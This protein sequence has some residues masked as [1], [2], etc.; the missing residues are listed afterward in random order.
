MTLHMSLWDELCSTAEEHQASI[1]HLQ[2]R[3]SELQAEVQERE[4]RVLQL[5]ALVQ[6]GAVSSA[7]GQRSL[8]DICTCVGLVKTDL[9]Q[10]RKEQLQS[11]AQVSQLHPCPSR[12]GDRLYICHTVC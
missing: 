7:S 10:T 5:E 6:A 1:A 11:I 9:A 12:W 3:Q 4:A 2:D 8:S